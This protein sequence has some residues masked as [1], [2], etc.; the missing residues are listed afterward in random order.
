MTKI[1][2][3]LLASLLLVCNETNAQRLDI[4]GV[5]KKSRAA[6]CATIVFKSGYDSLTVI[7]SS[8]DSVYKSK[9][10]KGNNVWTQYADLRYEREQGVSDSIKRHFTLHTPYTQDVALTVPGSDKGLHQSIY[11]YKVRMF[12][13]SPYVWHMR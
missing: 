4:K 13:Y 5:R 7:S 11:E 6:D 1:N 9:D 8:L 10:C 3:L 12:D 2:L